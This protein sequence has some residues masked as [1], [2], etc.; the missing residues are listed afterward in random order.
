M[1]EEDID[2]FRR[3]ALFQQNQTFDGYIQGTLAGRYVVE[4]RRKGLNKFFY[5]A[6]EAAEPEQLEMFFEVLRRS[7]EERGNG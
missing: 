4:I 6:R 3:W 7:E 5:R 2:D 1:L